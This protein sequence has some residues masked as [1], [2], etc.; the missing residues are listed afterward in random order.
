[1]ARGGDATERSPFSGSH[2][3]S[4]FP[5][6]ASQRQIAAPGRGVGVG[7]HSVSEPRIELRALPACPSLHYP[8]VPDIPPLLSRAEAWDRGGGLFRK[9]ES[10]FCQ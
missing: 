3:R 9:R 6:E 1:M 4:H 10:L 8:Q 7:S 2:T 5:E